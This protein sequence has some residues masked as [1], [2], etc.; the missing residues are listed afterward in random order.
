MSINPGQITESKI[1]GRRLI[2][3]PKK[4]EHLGH[5]VFFLGKLLTHLH[6]YGKEEE[7]RG[8]YIYFE[9]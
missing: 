2:L 9:K 1:G 5:S 7:K 8:N 3:Q 4:R 6:L